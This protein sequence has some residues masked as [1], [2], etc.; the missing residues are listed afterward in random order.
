MARSVRL[1]ILAGVLVLVPA[2]T[3]RAGFISVVLT[4]G[5]EGSSTPSSSSSFQFTNP[6]GSPLIGISN[7]SGVS[8][9]QATTAG[10]AAF[11]GGLGLPIVLDL[12]DGTGVVSSSN[13]PPE[14]LPSS[15][16]SSVA[17][18]APELIPPDAAIL[19]ASLSPPEDGPQF[20]S[21]SLTTDLG[22]E[23]GSGLI[24]LPSG[25]WWVIGLTPGT[26]T[27]PPVVEPPVIEPPVVLP[28]VE[29][30]SVPS[31]PNP[32]TAATPEP[33][34]LALAALGAPLV[35]AAR[36]LRRRSDRDETGV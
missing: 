35:G 19:S 34:T 32:P 28:P 15:G 27:V 3:A 17:P 24:P 25:G 18:T 1:A 20:L 33:A 12:S 13:A 4:A 8:S 5:S 7:L 22:A 9:A 6:T 30:P 21:V 31:N 26:E 11:F 16:L 2:G 36:W 10:G 23:L 14:A 29:V